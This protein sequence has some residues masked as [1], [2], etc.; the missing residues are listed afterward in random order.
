AYSP[1]RTDEE[2]RKAADDKYK[3]ALRD[4][5]EFN[6]IVKPLDALV[7]KPAP[8][9]PADGWVG[10]KRPDVAGRPYLVHFWATWCGPCKA[11]LPRR[12]AGGGRGLP[13]VGMHPAGTPAEEVE[14]VIHDQKLGYPTLLA[15]GKPGDANPP[16]IGGYP[17]GVFPYCV[18][19]DARGRVVG[20]GP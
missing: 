14:R 8:T 2:I 18:L 16:T 6:R 11:D 3:A 10:G 13:G 1:A 4:Q 19:V 17:A 9:L 15:A 5:E 7:G 20:H 12:K